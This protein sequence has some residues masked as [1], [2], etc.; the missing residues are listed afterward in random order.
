MHQGWCRH[1]HQ[2]HTLKLHVKVFSMMDRHCRQTILYVDR[3]CEQVH[4]QE[5]LK[6]IDC[7]VASPGSNFILGTGKVHIVYLCLNITVNDTLSGER[8]KR[9]AK[10]HPLKIHCFPISIPFLLQLNFVREGWSLSRLR[11]S[12]L[13]QGSQVLFSCQNSI[14]FQLP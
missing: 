13:I 14:N 7:G 10:L 5:R 6:R 9:I 12:L 11:A 1:W 2:R 8:K 3:S 4:F